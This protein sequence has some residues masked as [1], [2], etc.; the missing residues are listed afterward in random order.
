ME[1]AQ[2]LDMAERLVLVCSTVRGVQGGPSP[3]FF[4]AGCV[5]KSRVGEKGPGKNWGGSR[6]CVS[7]VAP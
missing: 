3:K 1:M 6:P 4:G 2:L 5:K 7:L